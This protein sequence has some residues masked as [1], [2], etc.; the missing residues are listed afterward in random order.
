MDETWIIVVFSATIRVHPRQNLNYQ[1]S[2]N[3]YGCIHYCKALKL[4]VQYVSMLRQ[5]LT[6]N[7]QL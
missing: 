6:A 5:L 3:G 7:R 2:V 4:K 1:K